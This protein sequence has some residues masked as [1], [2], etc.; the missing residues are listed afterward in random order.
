MSRSILFVPGDSSARFT[1]KAD[2]TVSWGPGNAGTDTSLARV[3]AG[4]LQL[5]RVAHPRT[6]GDPIQRRDDGHAARLRLNDGNAESF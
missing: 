6:V 2:G 3:S 5:N 1:L 4:L